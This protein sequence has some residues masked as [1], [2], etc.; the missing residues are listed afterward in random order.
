MLLQNGT[1]SDYS[2]TKKT[3]I[4]IQDHK[5]TQIDSN[6]QPY[7]NEKI[8][9]CTGKHIF[10][11]LIDLD[12]SPK[13]KILNSKTLNSLAKKCL[14][15]GVGSILLSAH[16]NPK[17]NNENILE[18][19]DFIDTTLPITLFS[20]IYTFNEDQKIANIASLKNSRT[21]TLHLKSQDLE[22][23]NLLT[24]LHYAKMLNLS[25]MI[26]PYD[27]QLAQGVID[28]GQLATKLGLPSIPYIA[29]NKEI[30]KICEI[31]REFHCPV[32]LNITQKEGFDYIDFF[33]QRGAKITTQ[34][35]LHH[36]ILDENEYKNYNT[37]AKM[38]PPLKNKKH[39]E[40]LLE[41][42][43]NNQIQ[44]LTSLQNATYNSQKDEVFELASNGVDTINQYF[45]ILFTYL[46]KTN[47]ITLEKLLEITAKN[48]ADFL[49]LENKGVLQKD[50]D[51]DLIIV[52]LNH[53]FICEDSYSPYFQKELYGKI[54]SIILQGKIY[55]TN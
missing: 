4:R 49:G 12:V 15:G 51:A 53:H 8:I 22:G 40:I 39:K 50:K 47:L 25:L 23:Q 6:L 19:I 3:N 27:E 24:L 31:S 9:D 38:F 1:I 36:L 34:T 54:D 13:N 30:V 32:L 43:Q 20:S 52:D 41:K 35:P 14:Q 26:T 28:S 44:C 16:T 5:I 17:S 55:G 2:G 42:L 29:W 37:K 7:E 48:Q 21:K 10:P 46:V 33:N 11:A 18:L 45:S